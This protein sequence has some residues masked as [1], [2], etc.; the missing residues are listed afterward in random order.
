MPA[1]ESP[2]ARPRPG[3]DAR[4]PGAAHRPD[5]P[6]L[7]VRGLRKV[8]AGREVVRGLDLDAPRGALTAVLGPNG[9]GKTTTI[10]CCEGLRDPDGGSIEVLGIDRLSGG[11]LGGR[12]AGRRAHDPAA[13]RALRR[14]VGVMLQDGGLPKAPSAR[15][16][17]RHV[18][19]LHDD[20]WPTEDLLDR[21]DL[22]GTARTPVRR[23]SGGQFQRLAL[24]CA[25]VGRPDLVFLDEPSAG[26][27]PRAR[28]TVWQLIRELRAAG[29]SLVLTTHL[30]DEVEELA[31]LVTVVHEGR[32]VATGT[33][34][35]L[36]AGGSVRI[37]LPPGTSSDGARRARAA[38]ADTG[39]VAAGDIGGGAAA[40]GLT[41]AAGATVEFPHQHLTADTA[42]RVGAALRDAGL[43]AAQLTWHRRSL[44]DVFLDLTGAPL[45]PQEH[46]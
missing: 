19:S 24:A 41:S 43:G 17:L 2:T 10:E 31:D 46:R 14:R 16:V 4:V 28:R 9:A 29:T 25:V 27:D 42:A 30:M 7:R 5:A 3:P 20:P 45:D 21:L 40:P 36:V 8:Y 1:P 33:P 23:L 39:V 12:G 44:E 18:A 22:R 37:T 11:S 38:L 6:A 35:E 13:A 15:A 34:A 26:L 32:V